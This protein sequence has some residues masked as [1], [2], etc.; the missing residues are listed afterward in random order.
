MYTGLM[1][2]LSN[3]KIL[4]VGGGAVA[5]RRAKK[6]IAYKDQIC[7]VAREVRDEIKD[8]GISYSEGDFDQAMMDGVGL[9]VIATS[10]EDLADRLYEA[11]KDKGILI[12]NAQD[13]K[14]GN[15]IFPASLDL[16]GIDI[17]ISTGGAYPSLSSYIRKDLEK[18]YEKFDQDFVSLLKAYR[19]MVLESSIKDKEDILYQA[20]SWTKEE[21]ESEIEKLEEKR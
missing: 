10:D 1:V 13:S 20:L 2:D 9:L 8:L 4:I 7:L 14:K 21:L 6:L 16:G 11:Y 18:R 3:T 15:V 12:N 19:A 17:N 5:L